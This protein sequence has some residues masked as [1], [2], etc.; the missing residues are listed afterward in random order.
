[1]LLV[2]R[3]G[4]LRAL[5]Q[6]VERWHGQ[7]EMALVNELRRLAVEEGH[8]QGRDVG[9]VHVG[10]GHDD[11]LVVAQVLFAIGRGSAA[12]KGL[13][14]VGELL[15]AGELVLRR[16]S[17]VEDLAAQ[18]QHGLR[19]PVARLLGGTAGRVTLDDEQFGAIL[20]R[21]R[22]IGELAGKAQL[23]DGRLA[24]DVL[25]LAALDALLGAIDDEVQ[26]PVSL[27]RMTRQ[28]MIEMIAHR[29]LDN[30]HGLHRGE[31]V[32]GLALKLRLA[33]EDREERT[34]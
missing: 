8:Q 26:Q 1:M 15:V 2:A 30:A 7:I 9:T 5:R 14:E 20:L 16:R 24:R 4:N 6:L 17:D 13:D 28:P 27:G 25:F 32:L 23:A 21:G 3:I 19:F 29:V 18:R 33:D 22:A 12:A 10:I 31:L 11:D 34:R